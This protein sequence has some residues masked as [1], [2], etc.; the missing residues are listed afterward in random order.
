[1]SINRR[2]IVRHPKFEQALEQISAVFPR[3]VE[4]IEGAEWSLARNAEHD[5]VKIAEIGV[6]Q[7]RLAGSILLPPALLYYTFTP[8][9]LQMLLI[10][11]ANEQS[12]P[13]TGSR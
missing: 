8:R 6:W 2:G 1:M 7:A 3:A 10:V 4:V 5:G 11:L 12:E 13:P 9:I